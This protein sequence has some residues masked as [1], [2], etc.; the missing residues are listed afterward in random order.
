MSSRR[1]DLTGE[2]FGLLT[3]VSFA[4]DRAGKRGA[5]WPHWECLCECGSTCYVAC[6]NISKYARN[7][8]GCGCHRKGKKN[9]GWK[10]H[11]GI[12]GERWRQIYRSSIS[13]SREIAFDITIEEAWSLFQ[14]QEGKCALTGW[15]LHIDVGG[16]ASLD[17]IDS[18]GVYE[19]G[20]V[21]WTH[22]HAN[23]SKNSLS[24]AEFLAMCQAVVD[25]L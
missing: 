1:K 12:S 7:Q 23:V 16:T 6:N 19:L 25:N 18:N 4:G 8:S 20:N 5:V 3:V 10:E 13:R 14:A 17:R 21:Q 11:G 9:K 24:D 22:K 2:K 15:D